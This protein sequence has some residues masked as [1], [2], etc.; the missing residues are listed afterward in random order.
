[1]M[2]RQI[3]IVVIS[4]PNLLMVAPLIVNMRVVM[5]LKSHAFMTLTVSD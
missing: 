2:M 3:I 1:M 5:R 4:P